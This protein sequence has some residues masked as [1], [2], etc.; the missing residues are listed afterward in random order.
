MLLSP[1]AS[2][3]SLH[4]YPHPRHINCIFRSRA[5]DTTHQPW[6]GCVSVQVYICSI[7]QPC[8]RPHLRYQLFFSSIVVSI[9]ACHPSLLGC[10]TIRGRPGFNSPLESTTIALLF[11]RCCAGWGFFLD[12]VA[13]FAYPT[14]MYY[15]AIRL[16]HK[17]LLICDWHSYTAVAYFSAASGGGKEIVV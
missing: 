10:L 4:T 17:C 7:L 12:V 15:R 6:L 9:S 16:V 14:R 2:F 13:F 1:L 3:F 5:V 11:C 8:H